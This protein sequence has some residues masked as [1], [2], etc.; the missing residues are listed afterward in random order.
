MVETL[1]LYLQTKASVTSLNFETGTRI[2]NL[3]S[4]MQSTNITPSI[5]SCMDY[6]PVLDTFCYANERRASE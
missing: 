1:R 5:D 4:P 2:I 3:I 6:T